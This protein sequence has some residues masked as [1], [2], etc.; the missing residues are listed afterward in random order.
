M[1]GGLTVLF[2]FP[3]EWAFSRLSMQSS[4]SFARTDIERENII[5]A[6]LVQ[7]RE[8]A[9]HGRT[10]DDLRRFEVA[11]VRRT[12]R[13]RAPPAAFLQAD[14]DFVSESKKSFE[15]KALLDAE[16]IKAAVEV[17]LTIIYDWVMFH[18]VMKV[19]LITLTAISDSFFHCATSTSSRYYEACFKGHKIGIQ[20][21]AFLMCIFICFVSARFVLRRPAL[22]LNRSFA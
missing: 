18:C 19:V 7:A 14:L 9:Q 20:S 11:W 4:L 13:G 3:S 15:E 22:S 6:I 2:V 1:N 10:L 12:A 8:V 5:D 17:N 21:A 16:L